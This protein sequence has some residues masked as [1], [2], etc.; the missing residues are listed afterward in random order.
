MEINRK[1]AVRNAGERLMPRLSRPP[2]RAR[3]PLTALPL[4]IPA[5]VTRSAS[6]ISICRPFP[7]FRAQ[8]FDHDAVGQSRNGSNRRFLF[9]GAS[10][11]SAVPRTRARK[12]ALIRNLTFRFLKKNGF[13]SEPHSASCSK[14]RN[15]PPHHAGGGGGGGYQMVRD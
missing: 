14:E 8:S 2:S 1:M 5:S 13:T 12:F 10:D 6:A 7:A 9:R 4:S 15:C 3:S 11:G